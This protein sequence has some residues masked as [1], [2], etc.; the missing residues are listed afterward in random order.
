MEQPSFEEILLKAELKEKNIKKR[1]WLL[2]LIPI[3]IGLF[4]MLIISRAIITSD[5]HL[6]EIRDSLKQSK[7]LLANEQN[8]VAG[9]RNDEV[10]LNQYLINLLSSTQA[11]IGS[12]N[13]V[14]TDTDWKNIKNAIVSLPAGKRKLSLTIALLTTWKE[15]PFK[16]GENSPRTSFDSPGYLQY[17]LKQVG[18]NIVRKDTEPLSVT[19]MK[20]FKKVDN[21]LPG[22]LV[23]YKG[24][25]GDGNFGLFYICPSDA[26]INGIG[27][28]TLQSIAPLSIYNG[29]NT[30]DYP[31]VGYYRV[32]Y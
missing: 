6:N 10:Q 18:I 3:A 25:P 17:V 15:I 21:P 26:N 5:M 9:L 22:D 2:T 29:I 23:F 28:G 12:E 13:A 11:N 27:V 31:F 8:K 4:F 14:L 30:A 1:I 20:H 19:L 16:L 7:S 32:N 24:Q